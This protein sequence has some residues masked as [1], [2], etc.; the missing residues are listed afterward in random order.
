MSMHLGVFPNAERMGDKDVPLK[1]F[2]VQMLTE[3][4]RDYL[5]EKQKG[6]E[7][8][9]APVYATIDGAQ[10]RVSTTANTLCNALDSEKRAIFRFQISNYVALMAELTQTLQ[11]HYG[12]KSPE[13]GAIVSAPVHCADCLTVFPDT[14]K[15]AAML[16][17]NEPSV[18]SKCQ[19]RQAFLV[20]AVFRPDDV[21]EADVAALGRYWRQEA[22]T[23]WAAYPNA[24]HAPCSFCPDKALIPCPQGYVT[25]PR[26]M[27]CERC[28]EKMLSEALEK[29]RKDPDYYG[30]G[31][32]QKLRNIKA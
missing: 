15:L 25:A 30:M 7:K 22:A 26:H 5:T 13:A 23:M 16:G 32:L 3:A 2:P 9:M 31:L 24:T 4:E 8:R 19:S 18:C 27:F 14:W 12:A 28:G 17:T 10:L 11:A 29:L 21:T 6:Q 1:M 20:I